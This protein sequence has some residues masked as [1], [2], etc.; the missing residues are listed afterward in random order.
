MLLTVRPTRIDKYIA[1]VVSR[2]SNP[3]TQETT[4]AITWVADEHV[5]CAAAAL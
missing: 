2:H 5:F 4:E 1:R 3:A